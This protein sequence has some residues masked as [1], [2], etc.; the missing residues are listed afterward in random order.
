MTENLINNDVLIIDEVA[1]D[2]LKWI[3]WGMDGGEPAVS[4]MQ[5]S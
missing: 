1:M 3:V 4:T 5:F 2:K